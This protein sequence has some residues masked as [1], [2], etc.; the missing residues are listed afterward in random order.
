MK[1]FVRGIIALAILC[2]L[3]GALTYWGYQKAMTGAL[4]KLSGTLR[5]DGLQEPVE[6]LRDEW[7][8]PHVYAKNHHDL[9]FAQGFI[10]AQDRWWQMDF[11]RRIFSGRLSELAGKSEEAQKVDVLMRTL[12]LKAVAQRDFEQL[13]PELK[14]YYTAFCDGVNAYLASRWRWQLALEYTLLWLKGDKPQ[15]E[16]WTP[17][18][19][20]AFGKL[21]GYTFSGRDLEQEPLRALLEKQFNA[22][23]WGAWDQGYPW[24]DHPTTVARE[25]IPALNGS[26]STEQVEVQE[27]ALSETSP[28]EP[29]AA[30]AAA[31]APGASSSLMEAL[32][33]GLPGVAG[34]DASNAWAVAG[35]RTETGKPLFASDPH[36]GIEIPNLWYEIGLHCPPDKGRDALDLYGYAAPMLPF[37]QAGNNARICWGLTNVSGSDA[38]DLFELRINPENPL[39]YEW[40]GEWRD[41]QVRK[42]TILIAGGEPLELEI[43]SSHLGPIMPVPLLPEHAKDKAWSIHWA[44]LTEGTIQKAGIEAVFARNFDEFHEALRWWDYPAAN[45]PYADVDGNIGFQQ[46]GKFPYGPGR[47]AIRGPM[48][49]YSSSHEWEGF[50][51]YELLPKVLNPTSGLVV[52]ANNPAAPEEY[53]AYLTAKVGTGSMVDPSPHPIMGYRA[54]RIT[55]LLDQTPKHSIESFKVIQN[56]VTTVEAMGVVRTGLSRAGL[57]STPAVELIKK[58]DGSFSLD[59]PEALMGG[60]FLQKLCENVFSDELA[61]A[62]KPTPDM[63]L[64]R[65]LE[66]LVARNDS[67]APFWDDVTTEPVETVKEIMQ[68]S[69]D[70][71]YEAATALAGPD[72]AKWSWGAVHKANFRNAFLGKSGVADIEALVNRVDLPVPGAFST[73][74]SAKWEEKDGIFEMKNLP[75]YRRIVD[76]SD[77]SKSVAVNSTGQSGHPYSPNYADQLP[78]WIKGDYRP[79]LW[80]REQVEAGAKH[81]LTLEP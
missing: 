6:V 18:D 28:A 35:S 72:P 24:G 13:E 38:L 56:D 62:T 17:A 33:W 61:G 67:K 19:S 81:R 58:W 66:L 48:P 39:Q 5:A 31:P 71:A 46:V 68:K 42:E 76:L 50:I 41:L 44:G 51:D 74:N 70:Q 78:L 37:V 60:I 79:I 75:A 32:P 57:P 23:Q 21:M 16:P 34:V 11:Y 77:F 54:K 63:N 80:T 59:K 1:W 25:D 27:P 22:G 52:A 15:I 36:Q 69:I 43:R 29:V 3:G 20:L 2:V 10:Q 26:E 7:G 45:I 47:G 30:P 65:S 14:E 49:G 4:P 9:L 53:I 64:L 12:N 73:V 8:I 55:E 40:D